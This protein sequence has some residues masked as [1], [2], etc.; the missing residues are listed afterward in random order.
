MANTKYDPLPTDSYPSPYFLSTPIVDVP[1]TALGALRPGNE[2]RYTYMDPG[3]DY[4]TASHGSPRMHEM[5][6]LGSYLRYAGF[7]FLGIALWSPFHVGLTLLQV[8]YLP[9]AKTRKQL[10]SLEECS[11]SEDLVQNNDLQ[12]PKSQENGIPPASDDLVRKM[13]QHLLFF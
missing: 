2:Y 6:P 8:Q 4:I 5:A 13:I 3:V 7:R 10:L 9:N 12:Y 11:S 1:P